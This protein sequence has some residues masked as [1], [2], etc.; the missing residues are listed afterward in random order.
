MSSREERVKALLKQRR[1]TFGLTQA[2]APSTSQSASAGG[3]SQDSARTAP[4]SGH[5]SASKH[6]S[7][8]AERKSRIQQLLMQRRM[9]Q[10]APGTQ[11]K[12]QV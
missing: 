11:R 4:P 7:T 3:G 5:Q 8:D 12:T 2:Q 9:A 6:E 1:Q 10:H